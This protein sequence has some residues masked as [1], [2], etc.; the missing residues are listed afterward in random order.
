MIQICFFLNLLPLT[1]LSMT[2]RSCGDRHHLTQSGDETPTL[3]HS[4][5]CPSHW[6][7]S[8]SGRVVWRNISQHIMSTRSLKTSNT[9]LLSFCS[10]HVAKELIICVRNCTYV[11]GCLK[12]LLLFR[13]SY[14]VA[15]LAPSRKTHK[16]LLKKQLLI[17]F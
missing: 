5:H 8:R 7:Y 11:M 9:F 12:I 14:Y 2:S 3:E 17:F 16:N 13:C 6:P 1:P 4:L 15:S 10:S